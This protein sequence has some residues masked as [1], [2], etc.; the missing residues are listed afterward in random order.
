MCFIGQ[1]YGNALLHALYFMPMQ[2]VGF[3]QWKRRSSGESGKLRA[4]RFTGKQWLIYGSLYV[5]GL[6]LVYLILAR[7][8]KSA[9]ETFIKIAVLTDA[10][11]TMCNIFGQMLM[12]M[13]YME[14]WVFWI[15]VNVSSVIMWVVTLVSQKNSDYA[16]IYIIKYSFY[17]L[18]S[19]NGLRIWLKLSKGN[20]LHT[21]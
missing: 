16:V 13:A 21:Q 14:Q 18:N 15:G 2:F 5:A 10:I 1:K 9:A 8:D 7:F 17:L 3:F 12:S 11:S 6:I 19:L 20:N 4:R